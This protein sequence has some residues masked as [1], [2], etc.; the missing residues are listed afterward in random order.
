MLQQHSDLILAGL[1]ESDIVLDI[2]G[3]A[4]PFNRANYVLDMGSYETR[5][6]Y[7]RTFARN[8]PIPPLGGLVEYFTKGS[9]I[10]RDLCERTPYPFRDKEIDYVICSHT[11]EDLRDPLWVCSEMIR[12]AKRGYIEIPSR[13]A[14]TCRGWECAQIA[15]LSHHRWLIEITDGTIVFLQKFHMIH[16][17][18]FS[19]PPWFFRKLE[20]TQKM[21]WLF[22]DDSFPYEELIMHGETQRQNLRAFVN[23]YV[24]RGRFLP[25]AVNIKRRW[26]DRFDRRLFSPISRYFYRS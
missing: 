2:G 5:G 17:W 16:Q 26:Q 15:G 9:W 21:T 7:N 10:Q 19:L 8:N 12:I 18:E 11:L 23:R 20:E 25:N 1:R 24:H 14:E 4:H 6:Y 13:L 22:W 3:W